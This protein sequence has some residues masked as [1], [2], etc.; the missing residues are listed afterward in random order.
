[1]EVISRKLKGGF[2]MNK[3]KKGVSAV[4]ATV[5]I[6]L[7]TIAAVTIIWAAVI[8]MITGRLE[9][10]TIC[11]DAM[12]QVRL[13]D[14]GYTCRASNGDN[15]SVQIKHLAKDFDLADVQ[16]LV[17]SGGDTTTFELSNDTTTI[18]P[19]GANIPFPGINEEKVYVID[20]S[21]IV[22]T[23]EGVQIAPVIVVGNSEQICDASF[24]Q[25]LR[26]C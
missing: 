5:L 6:I 9:S 18:V 3:N 1:M 7:I 23:I 2:L 14:E 24:S 13:L 20:T 26:D 22:G 15:V 4:V 19:I 16:V 25:V 11:S 8:P 12:S 10:S 21:S 17:S